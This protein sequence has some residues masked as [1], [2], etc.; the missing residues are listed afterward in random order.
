MTKIYFQTHGCSN[1][2]S[3]TEVMKG[4]LKEAN[5][6]ILSLPEDADIIVINICTVKGED[7]ALRN[8]R[9]LKEKFPDK[10]LVI[11]GCISKEIIMPLREITEDAPL[12]NTHNI[13]SIVDVV[14]ELLNDNVVE[15]MTKEREIKI[16][17]PKVRENPIVGIVPIL[18]GCN[19]SCSYCSVKLIKGRLLS[20]PIETIVDEVKKC[21]N[22]GCKEIWITSMDN[23][24][25]MLEHGR[26]KLPELMK[27]V[28]EIDGKFFVR[29]GMMNPSDLMPVLDDMIEIYKD[30]KMFKFLHIPVQSGND[31][32]LK[33]M[34]RKYTVDDFK[35]IVAKFRKEILN[36]TISTDVIAGF[37]TET[38][39]QFKDSLDLIKEI[40]PEVLNISMFRPRPRT[41]A[42]SMAQL[43]SRISKDRTRLLTDIFQNIAR[44]NNEKWIDWKGNV[45]IDEVGK[46]NSFIGRNIYYKPVVVKGNLKL[47][48]IA[49]VKIKQVTS[50]DLR[51]I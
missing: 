31:E 26:S 29:L 21:L 47:G 7:T 1:N 25:Y 35:N 2:F 34:N 11:A 41:N 8:I 6:S 37:P 13:K 23:A 30:P 20:Y 9:K 10:K 27:K 3:E 46:E 51:G 49:E 16:N 39:E 18:S 22:D 43:P 36:I 12:I 32:I 38:E 28:L 33:L 15:M 45:L 40:K 48:D 19:N 5:F 24:A 50:F 44:M 17:L 42:F 14:E 4:L